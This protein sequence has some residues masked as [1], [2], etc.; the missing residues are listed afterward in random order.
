MLVSHN[1]AESEGDPCVYTYY[2]LALEVKDPLNASSDSDGHEGLDDRVWYL[3]VSVLALLT[4]TYSFH[5]RIVVGSSS[6]LLT[7]S[8]V[9]SYD[10]DPIDGRYGY[11]T[12][13]PYFEFP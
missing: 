5:S 3:H 12:I 11:V 7:S 8:G 9:S 1:S 6:L 13:G 10:I 4:I 2:Y